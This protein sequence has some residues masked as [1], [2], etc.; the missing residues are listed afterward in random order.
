MSEV[1]EESFSGLWALFRKLRSSYLEKRGSD[2]EWLSDLFSTELSESGSDIAL[3]MLDETEQF[4]KRKEELDHA[5]QSG[6]SKEQW[7]AEFLRERSLGMPVSE[8]GRTL[9]ALEKI[10][11]SGSEKYVRSLRSPSKELSNNSSKS[12]EKRSF[13][14]GEKY[15]YHHYET[16]RI[17]RSVGKHA[18]LFSLW[19]H[20]EDFG[21][22]RA[23]E[24]WGEVS[25]EGEEE[26]RLDAR[27]QQVVAL[28]GF[29][30]AARRG[31]VSGID[32]ESSPRF[33]SLIVCAASE[34]YR[35]A[36][37][38]VLEKC[39]LTKGVDRLARIFPVMMATAFGSALT[40]SSVENVRMLSDTA[41]IWVPATGWMAVFLAQ[42]E[43]VSVGRQISKT[44]Q[45]L[46]SFAEQV[47][48]AAATALPVKQ[49]KVDESVRRRKP[50]E[51]VE[52]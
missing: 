20:S 4:Q 46:A 48:K 23:E 47:A 12:P 28:G 49:R 38:I 43:G 34:R 32:R 50:V 15:E 26:R 37:E 40:L 6:I 30:I 51:N 36:K 14:E 3:E 22:R 17:A 11:S 9:T 39:S 16:E 1:R 13:D 44:G 19:I 21:I 42:F 18:S 24:W 45:K 33:L 2:A 41:S 8:Y 27:A 25:S 52:I 10:L 7:L 5:I 29:R 31:K 35:T